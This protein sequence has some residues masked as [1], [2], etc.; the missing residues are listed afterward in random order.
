MILKENENKVDIEIRTTVVPSLIYKKEDILDIAKLI[1]DI[2]CRWVLQQFR[3]DLGDS[4]DPN[5]KN[6]DSPSKKFLDN[7]KKFCIEKYS[8][9]RIDLKA[10]G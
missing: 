2:D 9:L 3:P 5:L 7:L 4:I 6:I 8:N 10:V 1:K